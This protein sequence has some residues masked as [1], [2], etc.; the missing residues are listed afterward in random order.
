MCFRLYKEF[1]CEE[2]QK[3]FSVNMEREIVPVAGNVNWKCQFDCP[4]SKYSFY[5]GRIQR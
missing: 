1:L 5:A 4:T 2:K 3:Y